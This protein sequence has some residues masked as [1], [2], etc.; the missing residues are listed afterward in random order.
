MT[1]GRKRN[2]LVLSKRLALFP[3][4]G[5]DDGRYYCFVPRCKVSGYIRVNNSQVEVDI[6]NSIGWYDREF[7]GDIQKWYTKNT[8]STES[9]S[10][11]VSMQLTNRWNLMVYTLWDVNIYN[12]D[13]TI[14]D[15]KAMAISPEGTRIQCDEH[16]FEHVDSWTSMHTL[17][18]YGTKWRLTVP[19]L[20]LDISVEAPFVKQE[21]RTI[22]SGRGYWKGRV[23]IAGTMHG[24]A[25]DGLGFV[26]VRSCS[27]NLSVY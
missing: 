23:S 27:Q 4:A 11:R 2:H 19:Q 17:N 6:N 18:E 15:K 25:V 14:R 5:A 8:S 9:S 12:G 22:C 16:S 20:D 24:A 10:T 21:V 1:L 13:H 26:E 7:G 3:K